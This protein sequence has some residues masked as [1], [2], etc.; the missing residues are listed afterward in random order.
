MHIKF[1]CSEH[2]DRGCETKFRIG[3]KSRNLMS[4]KRTHKVLEL[5]SIDGT[6]LQMQSSEATA[7]LNNAS[8]PTNPH[9]YSRFIK[10]LSRISVE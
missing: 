3:D 4:Q 6:T 2:V 9:C 1:E 7:W 10:R 5:L 8:K